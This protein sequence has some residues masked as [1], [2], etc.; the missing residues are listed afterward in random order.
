MGWCI[1]VHEEP[2][3]VSQQLGPFPSDIFSQTFQHFKI[4]LWPWVQVAACWLWALPEG[5]G[6]L[7]CWCEGFP[8]LPWGEGGA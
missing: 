1:T 3:V 7:P 6:L 8:S 4:M 5:G 2:G